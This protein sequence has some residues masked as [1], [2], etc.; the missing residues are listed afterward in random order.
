MKRK[1]IAILRGI[2]PEEIEAIAGA[3]INAGITMIE[4]P[5][6]SPD[7]FLSIERLC[8]G[9]KGQGIFGAGTV[10][11]VLQV[12][13]LAELGADMI[14]SPNCNSDVIATTKNKGLLSYP[15]VMT[16]TECFSAL[17][18]GADG[19]KFFPGELI[20]P[21]GLRAMRATLP[22]STMCLAVGGARADNFEQWKKAGADGF[23]I[24]SALYKAGDNVDEVISKANKL[25]AV[26]DE[27]MR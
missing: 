10:L 20:G 24:G 11:D 2:T 7:A 17:R 25:V 9:F 1:L 19:L 8:N 13:Q 22:P 15:G 5:M 18:S 3:L 6:N 16:P 14:V 21:E 23:G 12:E 26:Y 4:V 27:V